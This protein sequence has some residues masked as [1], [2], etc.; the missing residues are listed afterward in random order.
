MRHTP[1]D[2]AVCDAARDLRTQNKSDVKI[3]VKEKQNISFRSA[4][5][6]LPASAPASMPPTKDMTARCW[7]AHAV[8]VTV[9]RFA[10]TQPCRI[11]LW[12]LTRYVNW[13]FK[14]K[15]WREVWSVWKKE[16]QDYSSNVKTSPSTFSAYWPVH[17]AF[18]STTPAVNGNTGTQ[19]R[20]AGRWM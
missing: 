15:S 6:P 2:E 8:T 18:L 1:S 14:E 5:T 11:N 17:V 13:D 12:S 10:N 4:L 20:N 3:L 19:T 9:T 7:V 16:M